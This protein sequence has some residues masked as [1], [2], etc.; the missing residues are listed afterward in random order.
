MLIFIDG[1]VI[2]THVCD[3]EN[4]SKLYAMNLKVVAR[5]DKVTIFVVLRTIFIWQR[6]DVRRQGRE[7]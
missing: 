6:G 7:C 4:C 3:I 5:S 2:M 1:C